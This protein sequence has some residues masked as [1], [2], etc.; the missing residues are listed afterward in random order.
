[1]VIAA[2]MV[3]H[4]TDHIKPTC[5][6]PA[7]VWKN[8]LRGNHPIVLDWDLTDRKDEKWAPIRR[9][10]GY[11]RQL[12]DRINLAAMTPAGSLTSNGYCLA[13][14]GSEYLVYV[15][16]DAQEKIDLAKA[17]GVFDVEWINARNGKTTHRQTLNGGSMVTL[18]APSRGILLVYLKAE[19]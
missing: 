1:M 19:A 10:M 16:N 5:S 14:R 9:A 2:R 7:F 12:A 11:S 8:F 6:D 15:S 18:T 3:L 13:H 4:D 17:P